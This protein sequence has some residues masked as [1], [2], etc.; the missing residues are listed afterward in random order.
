MEEISQPPMVAQKKRTIFLV[1]DDLDDRELFVEAI[2]DIDGSANV[3]TV[4]DPEKLLKQLSEMSPLPDYLFLDLNMPRKSG[5]ECLNEIS[6]DERFT[7][8][9]VVIYTT[10]I[11]PRDVTESYNK[12]AYCFIQKPNSY[13]ELKS[14]LQRVLQ[15]DP[16]S[17][18]QVNEQFVLSTLKQA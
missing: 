7:E 2:G 14:I 12:G 3:Q 5:K 15:S 17:G 6:T 9:K 1:D 18:L 11:N 13:T 4:E 8:M 16:A 10:S